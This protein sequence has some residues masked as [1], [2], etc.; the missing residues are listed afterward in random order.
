MSL[1]Y[2]ILVGWLLS[3]VLLAWMAMTTP[4]T[5]AQAFVPPKEGLTDHGRETQ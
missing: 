3:P 4:P 1:F 2:A 5:P